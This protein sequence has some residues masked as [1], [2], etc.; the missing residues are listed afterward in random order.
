MMNDARPAYQG[1]AWGW[2]GGRHLFNVRDHLHCMIV[3]EC[4]YFH[5]SALCYGGVWNCV[6]I[7]VKR[8]YSVAATEMSGRIKHGLILQRNPRQGGGVAGLPE[9][10]TP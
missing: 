9:K 5:I 3:S 1:Q 4:V 2:Q 6:R 7:G 8:R 10:G